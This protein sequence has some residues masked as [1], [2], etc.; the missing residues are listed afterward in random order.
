L[1]DGAQ[2]FDEIWYGGRTADA[3][4]DAHLRELDREVRGARVPMVL[5]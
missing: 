3:Q 1:R 5:A 2:I 4:A